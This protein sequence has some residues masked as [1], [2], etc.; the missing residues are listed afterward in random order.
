VD[1]TELDS[2]ESA[3]EGLLAPQPEAEEV[4]AEAVEESE[5]EDVVEAEFD[6]VEC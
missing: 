2:F 4:E 1:T 5:A 3:V 6:E